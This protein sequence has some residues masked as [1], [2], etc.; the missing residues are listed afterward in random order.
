MR[1]EERRKHQQTEE[2]GELC[3]KNPPTPCLWQAPANNKPPPPPCAVAKLN[4]E[5]TDKK[6]KRI[7]VRVWRLALGPGGNTERP[8]FLPH[9][10]WSATTGQRIRVFLVVPVQP[11]VIRRFLRKGHLMI[12]EAQLIT[13]APHFITFKRMFRILPRQ[14]YK[15]CYQVDAAGVG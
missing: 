12:T 7:S 5:P 4:K 14:M 3:D 15:K 9:S 2:G 13:E 11:Q 8:F 6:K 1:E 10:K